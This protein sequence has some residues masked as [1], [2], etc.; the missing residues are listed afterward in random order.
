MTLEHL[1]QFWFDLFLARLQSPVSELSAVAPK[2]PREQ[3]PD[4]RQA[5]RTAVR[6][7]GFRP[8]GRNKPAWE[9]LLAA[10]EKGTFPTI[11]PLV[12][13]ANQVSVGYGLP[14]SVVDGAILEAP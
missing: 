10:R 6:A 5:V 9:Y 4:T 12:D 3:I 2:L 7:G 11:N 8:S 1:P 14:I 13:L